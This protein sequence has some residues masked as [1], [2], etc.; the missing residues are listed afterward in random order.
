MYRGC[1]RSRLRRSRQLPSVDRRP[2]DLHCGYS[3]MSPMMEACLTLRGLDRSSTAPS[4]TSRRS[5]RIRRRS[6]RT[7]LSL[8]PTARSTRPALPTGSRVVLM[9]L[10]L[11]LLKSSSTTMPRSTLLLARRTR[12]GISFLFQLWRRRRANPSTNDYCLSGSL[13][14]IQNVTGTNV[15]VSAITGLLTGSGTDE[16]QSALSSGQLC[17]GCNAL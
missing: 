7:R 3:S 15:S 12:R 16:L 5:A 6:A 9:E 11:L 14:T 1:R 10:R 13:S 4:R 2:Q 8:R 17:T